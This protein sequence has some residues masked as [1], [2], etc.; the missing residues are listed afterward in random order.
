MPLTFLNA[1]E[2]HLVKKIQGEREIRRYLEE[3]GFVAGTEISIISELSGS[4]IVKIRGC[5]IALC[6]SLATKILVA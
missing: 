3:L 6:K 2:V 5:R 4:L 1:G